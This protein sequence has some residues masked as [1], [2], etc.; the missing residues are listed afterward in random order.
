MFEELHAEALAGIEASSNIYGPSIVF[1]NNIMK[2]IGAKSFFFSSSFSASSQT[3]LNNTFYIM[4]S[5]D[6]DKKLESFTGTTLHRSPSLKN[7]FRSSYCIENAS[8][9]F[10]LVDEFFSE[11]CSPFPI[12]TVSAVSVAGILLII[13]VTVCVVCSLRVQQVK[14]EAN[15]LGECT[16]QSFSTLSRNYTDTLGHPCNESVPASPFAVVPWGLAFPE[17]KTY[18]QNQLQE[19]T[20]QTESISDSARNSIMGRQSD[21]MTRNMDRASCPFN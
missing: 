18:Q 5:C 2:R 7:V 10:M 14:E 6:I 21:P 1:T 4:C 13:A 17:V 8:A 15:M 12:V 11:E 9:S 20:E 16:S 19:F 3:I